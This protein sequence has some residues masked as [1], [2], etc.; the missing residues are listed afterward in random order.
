MLRE[1]ATRNCSLFFLLLFCYCRYCL[2]M[3]F[4]PLCFSF[5]FEAKAN[6][7]LTKKWLSISIF[8]FFLG[9][10]VLFFVIS[11]LPLFSSFPIFAK[12]VERFCYESCRWFIISN[13]LYF[14]YFLIVLLVYMGA[15]CLMEVKHLNSQFGPFQILLLTPHQSDKS[16]TKSRVWWSP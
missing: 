1:V 16:N 3:S 15:Y 10:L 5:L 11:S 7:I 2:S 4:C 14:I 12:I 8:F 9:L 13:N 6:E